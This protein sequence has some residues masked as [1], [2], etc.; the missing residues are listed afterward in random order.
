MADGLFRTHRHVAYED[1]RPGFPQHLGHIARILVCDPKRLGLGILVHVGG[2]AIQNRAH[3]YGNPVCRKIALKDRCT[4][5]RGKDRLLKRPADLP[6]IDIKGRNSATVL[7]PVAAAEAS[8]SQTQ[9]IADR[10]AGFLFYAAVAAATLTALVWT[11]IYGGFDE[12]MITR[13][14][15]VLVIACPH[16]LG[17]AIPLVI[18]NT[19]AIAAQNGIDDLD[20]QAS[21][22]DS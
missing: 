2:D 16:A 3:L 14:V 4:L 9:L 11:V 13:V 1:F 5:R 10:A 8:K 22:N 6:P 20:R 21:T 12:R 18:A 19:T 17:L 15:T 7:K